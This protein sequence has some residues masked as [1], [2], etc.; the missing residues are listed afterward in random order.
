MLTEHSKVRA[1]RTDQDRPTLFG[2]TQTR[3]S[4][5]RIIFKSIFESEKVCQLF[6][7]IALGLNVHLAIFKKLKC[8]AARKSPIIKLSFQLEKINLD[9]DWSVSC[10]S[11]IGR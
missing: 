3:A 11:Q 1:A 7:V 6:D 9:S 2:Q 4:E 5:F 10:Q 8:Q